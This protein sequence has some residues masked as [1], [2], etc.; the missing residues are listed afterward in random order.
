MADH[1]IVNGWED[2]NGGFFDAGYYFS[3]ENNCTII[4]STKNWWAQ[5]EGLNILLIMSKI[6]PDE[7]I[8]REY[9]RRQW[10]YIKNYLLDDENGGW[11]EG[12]P[13]KEPHFKREPKRHIWKCSYHTGRSLMN[14]I[15]ILADKNS[16]LMKNENFSNEKEKI[17]VFLNQ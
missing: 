3:G 6:F 2:E 9:F 17:N 5:A 4:Q 15:K 14:C 1:A 12:G 8:Y 10:N 7:Q 11:F 13:D 16:Y